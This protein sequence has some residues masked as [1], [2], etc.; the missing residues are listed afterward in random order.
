M[1]TG[2]FLKLDWLHVL[3]KGVSSNL[4]L[5]SFLTENDVVL[6]ERSQSKLENENPSVDNGVNG[7]SGIF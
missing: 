7:I 4:T 6:Y 2:N 5:L 3:D 1:D